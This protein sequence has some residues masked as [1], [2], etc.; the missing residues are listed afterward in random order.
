MLHV[1]SAS[2]NPRVPLGQWLE[3]W[4]TISLGLREA[5]RRRLPQPDTLG[6]I[7]VDILC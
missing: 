4:R 6:A 2:I 3:N 1:L 7:I 5:S